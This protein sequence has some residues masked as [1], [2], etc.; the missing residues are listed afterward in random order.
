MCGLLLLAA[1]IA[2][3][4]AA[5]YIE[6]ERMLMPER[7]GE[8]V[9]VT[10]SE[11]QSAGEA[12]AEF[13]RAGA[14]TNGRELA[15]WMTRGGIDKKLLP[16]MYRVTAGRPKEVASQLASVKPEVP[17]VTILPGA[18][19]EDISSPLGANGAELLAMALARDENFP[20]PMRGLLPEKD[21]DRMTLLA[22]ETYAVISGDNRADRLVAAASGMW[23]KQHGAL[24]SDETTSADIASLGILAS[25][26]QKEA[27]IDSDRPI[28]AGVFKNRLNIG[29][30]LQSCATVVHAWRLRGV[31]ISSVSYNDVK[32]DSP[33]N[34]YIHKGLPPENIGTPSEISWN[35]ALRPED[36]DMLF[37]FAREDGSHVFTRT[38]KEHLDAQKK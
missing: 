24:I 34:T 28:I 22:P 8:T 17:R 11:G 27:L 2:F 38:Y 35:A 31:R 20:E 25:V 37:F 30:P 18:L 14:V 7:Y 3:G 19:F 9:E 36:T 10:V 6:H 21:R 13:E 32:V 33:F 4:A 29:M 26:V 16:G 1:A 5:I 15:R 23:W 12:A